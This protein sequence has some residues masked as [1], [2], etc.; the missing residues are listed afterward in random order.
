MAL[1][2]DDDGHI[3]GLITLE[4]V[5][6]EIVGDIEDEHDR[7]TAKLRGARSASQ[8]EAAGAGQ[9]GPAAADAGGQ[10]GV[11]ET[12]LP[13]PSASGVPTKPALALGWSIVS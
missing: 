3:L 7:P 5:L 10:D 2:R 13:A 6:E 4:D 1:V 9:A 11:K 12:S 8:R